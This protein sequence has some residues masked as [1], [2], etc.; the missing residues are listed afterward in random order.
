MLFVPAKITSECDHLVHN[1]N[2]LRMTKGGKMASHTDLV[3]VDAL[4]NYVRHIQ[5]AGMMGYAFFSTRI[6]YS[7]VCYCH[8]L[9]AQLDT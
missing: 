4:E 8:R 6:T 5:R 7:L 2:N 1:L 3:R 9:E